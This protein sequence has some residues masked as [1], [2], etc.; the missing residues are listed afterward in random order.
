MELKDILKLINLKQEGGYWDFKKEWY[1]SDNKGKQDL[2]HDIIC[3]ANN[4]E[5]RDA[6]LIIGIDEENNYQ[7][8]DVTDNEGRKNTQMLVDFLKNKSFAGGI[9]PTVYV[10][11]YTLHGKKIDVI[12]VKS[13][14]NTPYYLT[15]NFQAVKANHIYT[16]VQDVNTSI[17]KS[18]DL[19]KIE[20][21]WKK[22]FG[23][24]QSVIDRLEICIEDYKNWINSPYG[25]MQKYY[26]YFPEFTIYYMPAKDG[27]DGYEY[28]LFSQ[29]DSRPHWYDIKFK[30]HKTLLKE[31]GGV[32]LDGGR[33]FTPCPE[34]DGITLDKSKSF[35]WDFSY[36]YFT[37]GTFLYKLN[38]FFFYQESFRD[39][40]SRQEFFEVVLLF[41]SE[42]ERMIFKKYVSKNWNKRNEYLKNLS[43]PLIPNLP[44][45]NEGAFIEDYE[46]AL[47]LNK[48]LEEFRNSSE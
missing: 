33:Y 7:V 22:R 37:K 28:Y 29:T 4:L 47:V 13:D 8:V 43:I 14:K 35:S 41:E 15:N 36:R 19:D 42:D 11:S 1:K 27:R 3:I 16:R 46:N 31:L 30:Y 18:A 48:M 45:Y 40:F 32:A 26:K 2:L 23:L 25:E 21:L 44:Q 9:R 17:D 39:K 38:Q 24:T 6:F 12:F 5:N 20:Y 10:K 34:I